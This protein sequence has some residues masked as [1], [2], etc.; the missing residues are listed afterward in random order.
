MAKAINL[1]IKTKKL[2]RKLQTI[3]PNLVDELKVIPLNFGDTGLKDKVVEVDPIIL[4]Q[5]LTP[6][7]FHKPENQ[8]AQFLL[9]ALQTSL[10]K[11]LHNSISK[12]KNGSKK[13]PANWYSKAKFIALAVFGTIFF[14][15]EGFDGI[16]ALLGVFSVPAIALLAA[17]LAFSFVSVIVFYAFDLAEISKNLNIKKGKSTQILDVYLDE[18]KAIEETIR[19]LNRKYQNKEV[20]ELKEAQAILSMLKQRHE[21]LDKPRKDLKA[22]G[23]RPII[24]VA[25]IITSS[26]AG[27]IFFSGGFFA[28]Q[29]VALF[30]AGLVGAT[31]AP[32]F[33][34]VIVASIVVGLAAFSIYWFVERPG[35]ENLI[36][37]RVGLDKDKIDVFCE[38][39]TLDKSLV[40]LK[41]TLEAQIKLKEEN[42]ELKELAK[43]L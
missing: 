18:I 31:V 40:D 20:E 23:N 28:G 34:P 30:I 3:Q 9:Q 6:S 25:K 17:G 38:K 13:E 12:N 43:T 1:S 32:A 16:T 26:L 15:F 42:A 22:A 41:K 14:G 10:L 5:W 2:I 21:A 29:T 35:I 24:K 4:R 36:S 27:I 8:D 37:R 7:E 19:K 11:D 33:W 39:D